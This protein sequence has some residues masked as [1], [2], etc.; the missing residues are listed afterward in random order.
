MTDPVEVIGSAYVPTRNGIYFIRQPGPGEKRIL[1]FSSFANGKITTIAE[2]SRPLDLGMAISPDGQT[3]LYSQV[4][5]VGS[6]L[7]LVENFR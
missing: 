3:L 2:M 7:M 1:A 5:H 6:D 4:D